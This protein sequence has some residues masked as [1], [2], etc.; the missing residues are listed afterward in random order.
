VAQL[1]ARKRQLTRLGRVKPPAAR[2]AIALA[3][4]Q[5]YQDAADA[6]MTLWAYAPASQLCDAR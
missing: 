1:E 2:V 5:V 3:K 4:S 6:P